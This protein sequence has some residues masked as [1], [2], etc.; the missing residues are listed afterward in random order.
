MLKITKLTKKQQSAV[1]A[2]AVQLRGSIGRTWISEAAVF[3]FI[4]AYDAA[5]AE[6]PK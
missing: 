4:R 6:V 3:A 1:V 2:A 5:T